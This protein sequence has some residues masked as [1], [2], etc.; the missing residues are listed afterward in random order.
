MSDSV[1][2]GARYAAGP[3]G[4]GGPVSVSPRR[5]AF[6]PVGIGF[7]VPKL[8]VLPNGMGTGTGRG[9]MITLGP[10]GIDGLDT[11]AGGGS[12]GGEADRLGL[13]VSYVQPS[14]LPPFCKST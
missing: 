4:I 10:V 2:A 7:L 8:L 11:L 1:S 12:T 13:C 5:A 9:L 14:G 6:G 3:V